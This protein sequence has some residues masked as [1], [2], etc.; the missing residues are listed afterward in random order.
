MMV[1]ENVTSNIIFQ[2]WK[3]YH[4]RK[5]ATGQGDGYTTESLLDYPY[6]KRLNKIFAIDLS[7][8]E[9]LDTDPKAMQ[10]INFTGNLDR[11]EGASILF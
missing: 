3:Y 4:I 10:Q 5:I 11:A 6:F 9:T 2:L 8:Q 1:N 7:K